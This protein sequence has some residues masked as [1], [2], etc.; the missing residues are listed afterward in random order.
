M[1][2][3][4]IELSGIFADGYGIVPK[5]LMTLD[6]NKNTKLVLAYMLTF[7]GGGSECFPSVMKMSKDLKLSKPTLINAITDAVN[8]GLIR[9]EK[10]FPNDPLKHN[11]KYIIQFL[12]GKAILPSQS[13]KLTSVG[14][15]S[16][17]PR[18]SS[19]TSKKNNINTNIYKN[20]YNNYLLKL[21]DQETINTTIWKDKKEIKNHAILMKKFDSEKECKDFFAKAFKDKWLKEQGFLP[22]LINS[23]FTKIKLQSTKKTK[24][25]KSDWNDLS[26]V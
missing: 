2:E 20:I 22:S 26:G 18:S 24:K 23:M 21:Y 5:K 10:L 6:I 9:K 8:Q 12:D 7:T 15:K 17:P 3:N 19:F 1:S 14:E 4:R 16:L 13:K 11:N 25:S